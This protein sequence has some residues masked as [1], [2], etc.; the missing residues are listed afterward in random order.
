[1]MVA[2]RKNRLKDVLAS[3][4]FTAIL[5]GCSTTSVRPNLANSPPSSATVVPQAV[6]KF[7]A[8]SPRLLSMASAATPNPSELA[9]TN[10]K[11]QPSQPA[12]THVAVSHVQS[13]SPE[14]TNQQANVE[15]PAND[16]PLRL[17]QHD[18]SSALAPTEVGLTPLS[19]EQPT[20]SATQPNAAEPFPNQ[21]PIDLASA[22]QL[23][24][25]QN[26]Q[27]SFAR[28][29]I[30]EA[31]ARL[32]ASQVLWVPSL[33]AG[34]NYNKRDGT[35]QDVQGNILTNS[36]SS[37][38]TGFG[39]QAVG[40]GSPAV[41][42]LLMN[43]HVR[44][45]MFQPRIAEQVL[46]ARQQA[47]R[48]ATNDL[49]LDTAL[50]YMDL[51]EA[52]QVLAVAED[53]LHNAEQLSTLTKSF[54][55][56]GQG[57]QADADR[58]LTEL[59]VRQI[60]VRR[61]AENV[62]VSAIRLSRAL[63]QQDQSQMLVPQEP[64]LIP[65]ELVTPNTPLAELIATGLSNRPELAENRYL[66]GEAVQRLRREC[67]APLVPSVLLGL[68]YGGNGGSPNSTITN[69]GDRVDFDAGVYWEVRNLG[70]GEEY[71]RSGAKAQLDQTRWQQVR[72]MDQ[73]A[74]EVAESHAQVEAR[75][76]QIQLAE[77]GIASAQNA[78]RRS[79]ERIRDGQGLPIETLQSIQ[80]LD[81]TR[82]QYIRSVADY[83]RSQF[84]LQRS[85][86]WSIQ[87]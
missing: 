13:N 48:T 18:T 38:Y 17:A 70:F 30:Q 7:S 35:I 84:H 28:Q 81:Q 57:L 39:A 69:F 2:G 5:A 71:A 60:E 68:S 20:D 1:M 9:K 22:L 6:S 52:I 29:R 62:R 14:I 72:V 10:A 58:A 12:A 40:A 23:T 87:Q 16:I 4:V 8:R 44:D 73:V 63:G 41:P 11:L 31:Y 80:A 55:D 65:I 42:G 27:V 33:R 86:G 19:Q 61:A 45:A 3:M 53:S 26:P 46:G 67:Y 74:S 49:L 37:V 54:A 32:Q 76:S 75:Q 79:A 36:R 47:S 78:Y 34:I 66:V 50:K 24:A 25:G 64:A 85:L 77:A 15:Q 51:L 82:R 56:S 21:V 43:F 83:N 59:S